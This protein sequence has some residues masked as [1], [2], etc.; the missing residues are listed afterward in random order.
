[1]ARTST[2]RTKG[3]PMCKPWTFAGRADSYRQPLRVQRPYTCR[4]PMIQ[5]PNQP[6]ISLS[7]RQRPVPR[8]SVSI[9]STPAV[10]SP[11]GA[12][13]DLLRDLA[14]IALSRQARSDVK[15]LG[16]A[17]LAD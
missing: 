1:M 11:R 15:Q 7:S 14:D 8:F 6:R 10:F 13:I 9:F 5:S 2:R 12:R 3:C 16:D 17:R 4:Q